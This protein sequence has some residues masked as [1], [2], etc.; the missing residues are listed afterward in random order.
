MNISLKYSLRHLNNSRTQ[1]QMNWTCKAREEKRRDLPGLLRLKTKTK[2]RV[3]GALVGQRFFLPF[4][5]C[6]R[7][8]PVVLLSGFSLSSLSVFVLSSSLHFCLCV[9]FVLCFSVFLVFARSVSVSIFVCPLCLFCCL[10]FFSVRPL[11]VCSLSVFFSFLSS[12]CVSLCSCVCVFVGFSPFVRP[13]VFPFFCLLF[14]VSCASCGL[15]FS[16]SPPPPPLLCGL[17]LAFIKARECH[18]FV[19]QDNEATFAGPLLQV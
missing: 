2:L 14:C 13:L 9:F 18:A 15:V 10:V 3:I 11:C 8:S 16:S 1:Y 7:F 5:F 4:C 19:P 12:P 6:F 17:S